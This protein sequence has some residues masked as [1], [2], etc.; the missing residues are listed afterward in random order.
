VFAGGPF[1][2]LQNLWTGPQQ[3]ADGERVAESQ[4]CVMKQVIQ[5]FKTGE[6]SVAEVPPPAL[7]RGF[8]LVRNHF[9]LI[10]AGTE[11]ATVSTARAS[12]LG[13]AR[14]RPDLVRQVVDSFRRDGFA[15][16]LKRVRTKL[17]TL[18]ELGYSSAGTVLASM[19]MHGRFQPNDRVA[20][21]GGGYASHAGIV[22]VPQNLVVK[23]PETVGLDAAAF[24]TLGAIAMQGVRQ[25]NPRIG[26]FV[27]VIGLGLLG[28]ISA[29]ILRANGCQ[30]FGVDTADSMV[31]LA[32]KTSCHAAR[33]RSDAGLD[34]AFATFTGGHGF[35][36][37]IITA[38]T[39][40]SD[41]V[42]LATANLR[43]K[44]IIVIVGAVPMNIP[45]EPHFYKKELELKISCSYGPGRYDPTYEEQGQD[46][47]YGYVRWTENRNMEVFVKLLENR[48]VDLQPLMTHVFEI[49]QAEEAYDIVTGKTS[50]HHLGI[51]LKYPGTSEALPV[52]PPPQAAS[53]SLAKGGIGFIGAGSFAQKFLIPFARRGGKLVSVVT[54]RGVTAKSVGQKFGF[55]SHSTDAHDVL[56]DPAVDTVFIAT[57]HD[58]HAAFLV[59]ALEA[60]KNVFVEKP[61]AIHE[62]A[63]AQVLEVARRRSDCR[64][65]VG[66][67]RRFSPL[68]RKAREVFQRVPAPLLINYRVNAGFVPKE[69]W[70][71]TEQ[72]GGRILGEVCHFID[73]MQFLTSSEPV[74]VY[75]MS[76][77]A[78]NARM[79]DEDN[80]VISLR[81][82][83][84]SVGQLQYVACGDKL[85]DKERI[86][87]FGGAQTFI[88]DDFRV[89]EH[90]ACGR[91]RT[92]KVPGKGHREE[93]EAFLDAVSQGGGSPIPLPS[94]ALTSAT[95]FAILDSLRTGLPQAVSFKTLELHSE[96]TMIAS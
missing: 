59:A 83:N 84:G 72:G 23:V 21:G 50:E 85:L 32:A 11:R 33:T 70:T 35:D 3:K 17:E 19:D 48:N 61:L 14:Q 9:S 28:Q 66:Y 12:L 94:L 6:L 77:R 13:K 78:D 5:N 49:E 38:A 80:V 87:I 25:A 8:V 71:Q 96:H 7:A 53:R 36:A 69:H 40:S 22:T 58:T 82:Q 93:V 92:L 73:L 63:L 46:Y 16:T 81:F 65:M 2:A 41:P 27:C 75:A 51:L 88:I 64:L 15:E 43:Q 39:Q 54:S 79:P 86:E 60:G 37:V 10:S 26:E 74:S 52:E 67:N 18:K 45:R 29:Q 4:L 55:R 47:P 91:C 24:T 56:A 76:V 90:Y 44:G 31:A 57:R 30:V 62:D 20:C 42:E 89:G 1:I 34:S 68:A 95:T